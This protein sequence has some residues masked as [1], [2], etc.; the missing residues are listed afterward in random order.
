[1][2]RGVEGLCCEGGEELEQFQS[3]GICVDDYPKAVCR[4]C[5][6][7]GRGGS[8]DIYVF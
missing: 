1:M 7:L 5:Y 6:S 3:R 8:R 4:A 2:C